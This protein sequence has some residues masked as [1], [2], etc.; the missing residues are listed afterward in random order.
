[1]EGVVYFYLL[2]Q[3]TPAAQPRSMAEIWLYDAT[4]KAEDL[5]CDAKLIAVDPASFH[6]SKV[7][8]SMRCR[9]PYG[10]LAPKRQHLVCFKTCP[11]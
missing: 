7:L 1:M 11:F 2:A 4:L 3:T 10:G 8:P 6:S 9:A 5:L